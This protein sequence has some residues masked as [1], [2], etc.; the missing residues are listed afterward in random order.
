MQKKRRKDNKAITL[1]ALVITVIVLLILAGVTIS[2]LSGDNGILT[3]AAKAKE[4]SI[5]AKEQE[6]VNLAVSTIRGDDAYTG[7]N[8]LNANNLKNE[9]EKLNGEGTV[10][11]TGTQ[12]L[13]IKFLDTQNVYQVKATSKILSEVA[14]VGDYVEYNIQYENRTNSLDE[15]VNEGIGT[16][17]R[18]AYID[19]K[20]ETV[21]LIPEGI[22]LL[23]SDEGN[24]GNLLDNTVASE[25]NLMELEDIKKI[26]EQSGISLEGVE[27]R[28]G[29]YFFYR[30]GEDK[31]NILDLGVAYRI[32]TIVTDRY[33]ESGKMICEGKNVSYDTGGYVYV[34][35]DIGIRPVITLNAGIICKGGN[36]SK[37]DI[38]KIY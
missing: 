15:S 18:V 25:V 1:I 29:V 9:L 38:Y 5:K 11:V 14:K 12:T 6:Q 33:G 36:G 4:K 20:N 27:H 10:E 37:S 24:I 23:D 13:E 22:P 3:N 16:G 31:L 35:D 28:D 19:K 2:A 8:T 30:I 7:N 34:R 26:C 17:W 21:K 32:N